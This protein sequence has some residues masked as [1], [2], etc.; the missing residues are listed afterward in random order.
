MSNYDTVEPTPANEDGSVGMKD[1]IVV[2]KIDLRRD[3]SYAGANAVRLHHL[4]NGAHEAAQ[5]APIV[6][7]VDTKT[8]DSCVIKNRYGYVGNAAQ[9]GAQ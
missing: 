3:V 2:T 8:G 5:R 4:R 6:I 1:A 7:F 9:D